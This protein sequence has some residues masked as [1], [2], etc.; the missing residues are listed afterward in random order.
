[1]DI[2]ELYI[3]L[4]VFIIGTL[5][6]S[7]FSLA[8]YRIPRKLDIVCTRSFCPKCEHKLGFFD[9]IPVLS[10]IFHLGKC[11]YCG[12]K[13]SIRYI[14]LEVVSGL[15]FLTLYLLF[16]FSIYFFLAVIIYIIVVMNTGI[17]MNKKQLIEEKMEELKD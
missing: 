14:L 7:F 15:T 13:I 12:E 3:C 5:F 10:Y 16:K 8:N 9:L 1:M 17:Y 2:I 11:K 6:G 4:N